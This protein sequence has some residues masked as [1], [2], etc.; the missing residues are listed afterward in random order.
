M[1]N[2]FFYCFLKIYS[3]YFELLVRINKLIKNFFFFIGELYNEFN[4]LIRRKFFLEK[5][6]FDKLCIYIIFMYDNFI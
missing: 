5:K 2:N 4:I 3:D 6:I 1:Y